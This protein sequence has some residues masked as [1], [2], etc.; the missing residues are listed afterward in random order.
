MLTIYTKPNCQACDMAKQF[1][2]SKKIEYRSIDI[3]RDATAKDFVI[4]AGHRSVPQI[5]QNGELFVEG[6]YVGLIQLDDD[7]L[8]Q[9]LQV[10]LA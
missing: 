3:T 8:K 4:K 10:E 2:N 6:G 5:Y 9:K 7:E 1:L